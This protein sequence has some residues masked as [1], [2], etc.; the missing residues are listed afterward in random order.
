MKIS[1]R[2]NERQFRQILANK[3]S[4]ASAGIWLLIPELVRLGA[5]DIIKAWTGKTDV[6]LEPRITMQMVNEAALCLNRERRKDSL[7]HQEFELANGMGSLV[8]DEQV[9]YLLNGHTMEQAQTMLINLGISKAVIR[10][11]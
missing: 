2:D 9:H 4:A 11:L 5:W 10:P 7:G 1:P 8:T 6:D 3:V